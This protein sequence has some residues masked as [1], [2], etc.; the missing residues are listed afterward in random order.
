MRKLIRE[1]GFLFALIYFGQ[2]I[3]ALPSQSIFYWLKE[4]L[5]LTVDKIAY[6]SAICTIPW[7]IKPIYG[8]ISDSFPILER[9]RKPYL[10]I[11][12][13]LI[14]LAS[15]YIYCFGLSLASFLVVNFLFALCFAFN[16][17]VCDGIMVEA[18]QRLKMTGPFQSIQWGASG[19]AAVLCGAGGGYIAEYLNYRSASA[20][21]SILVLIILLC[22]MYFYSE[23]KITSTTR[24]PVLTL[25]K[26]WKLLAKKQ[27][28]LA[29]GFLALL[30]FSPSFGTA[31]MFKMRDVLHFDKIF[32]GWQSTIG[33]VA[34]V[35]GALIYWKISKKLPLKPM[36]FWTTLISGIITFAYLYFPN[37]QIA[38]IYSILFGVFSS[39]SLLTVMDYSARIV[40]SESA[41]CGFALVCSVLNLSGLGS[42]TIGGYLYPIIGLDWLIVISGVTTLLALLFIPH[43]KVED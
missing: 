35:I 27:F 38:V 10:L 43:L 12:Y 23:V 15:I 36:L 18:G 7:T 30:W 34:G 26:L 31:L 17:V 3:F 6:I 37:W 40:P 4:T 5:G 22:I 33:S 42:Q 32:L 2:G 25:P 16:D 21:L 28:M 20:I 39:V 11:N 9:H 8:W 19:V 13:V 41:G 14:I 1:Y 29:L 24:R